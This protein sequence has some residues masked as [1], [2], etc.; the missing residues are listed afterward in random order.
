M[1]E[2]EKM[3]TVWSFQGA[4][5]VDSVSLSTNWVD[6]AYLRGHLAR[7]GEAMC[8]DL[9]TATHMRDDRGY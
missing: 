4:P 2:E 9:A 7:S 1:K 5:T 3:P 8:E 6:N